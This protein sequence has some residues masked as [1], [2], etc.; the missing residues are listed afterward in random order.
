M[1]RRLVR[2]SVL[3]GGVAL[4]AECNRRGEPTPIRLGHLA[5]YGGS[6][7]SAAE[8]ARQAIALAT[9]E[10]DRAEG[11]PVV[12]FH[13]PGGTLAELEPEAVRLV[14]L[15]RVVGLLAGEEVARLEGVGRVAQTYTVPLITPAALPRRADDDY[16]FCTGL[17]PDRRGRFLARFAAQAFRQMPLVVL[18]AD[19]RDA[20]TL[21]DAFVH[22]RRKENAALPI[23]AMSYKSAAEIA[24]LLRQAGTVR[25]VLLAGPAQ[26]VAAVDRA[27]A[28]E[29]VPIFWGGPESGQAIIE[30]ARPAH[31]V[32]LA[33]VNP[34][35][36]T[37]R[38]REFASRYRERFGEAPGV[39]AALAYDD[40][41]LL[42][43]A[44][45]QARTPDGPE[46][47]GALE[48]LQGFESLAGPLTFS[49]EHVAQRPAFVLR[50]HA[51]R[52]EPV[53]FDGKA[54]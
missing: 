26:D 46:I 51:G 9:E 52:A 37:A 21:A 36:R 30:G 47:R 15:N 38:A 25:A 45:R 28:D 40:A 20:S 8:Q 50:V 33:T 11:R 31:E 19:D 22:E 42:I 14:T 7:R 27:V 10:A 16:L 32:Y 35:G 12:V 48:Q 1:S 34:G 6:N 44:A 24:G 43:G 3:L 41:R 53:S 2:F 29:K 23:T 18:T 49:K 54:D 5:S 17:P 4:L 39:G 13:P